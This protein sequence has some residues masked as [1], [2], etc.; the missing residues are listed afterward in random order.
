MPPALTPIEMKIIQAAIDCIEE[1]GV[2]GTTNRKIA[3]MAGVNSA[4]INY[5]FRSK[6]ALIERCMQVTLENAFDFADF[7]P[8]PG[9]T[10]IERCNSIFNELTAGGLNYPGITRSHFY[11]LLT[12]GRYD[13]LVVTKLNEFA[14]N[15]VED[16]RARDLNL[17][18]DELKMACA[19][20]TS[21]V[22]MA[23]LA[24]GLFSEKLGI[25]LAVAET[26]QRYIQRLVAR[27][28]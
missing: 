24:P 12:S 5:Y 26:R 21:A 9:G 16:L 28:L 17:E 15:L 23:I 4:A 7:A 11:S 25:D 13:S 27:L 3:A 19:Q 14:Q 20:I 10:A 18:Q 2:Q 8:L 1:Y 6:D 22:M